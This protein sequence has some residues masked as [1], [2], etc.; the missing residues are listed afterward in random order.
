M[1]SRVGGQADFVPF[2][3]ENQRTKS[4]LDAPLE[5]GLVSHEDIDRL[6]LGPRRLLEKGQTIHKVIVAWTCGSGMETP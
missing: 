2:G 3:T 1:V 6:R 4:G 5:K